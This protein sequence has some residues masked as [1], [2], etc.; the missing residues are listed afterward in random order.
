[1]KI[2]AYAICW[3]E[4][5]MLPY[6]LKH[7]ETFCDKI[8]IYD[9]ESTDNSRR[10]IKDHPKT[11]LRT[12]KT[13]SQIKDDVYLQIKESCV[14]DAKGKADYAIV[15]D[16]DEFL[17]HSNIKKF[18]ADN[19]S[20]SFYRPAGFEMVSEKFP[21]T[22]K[23]IYDECNIGI[24]T[25]KLCKP[26]LFNPNKIDELKLSV[27]GHLIYYLRHDY[28]EYRY[29]YKDS[30]ISEC[31]VGEGWNSDKKWL[32]E[33]NSFKPR[34]ESFGDSPLKLLHYKYIGL[35]YVTKRQKILAN[36]LSDKNIKNGWG[37]HY[38]KNVSKTF[39]DLKTKAKKINL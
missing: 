1:M 9:N 4:E 22:D 31:N 28:K 5:K 26:L 23:M 3:N 2:W 16:I 39:N 34:F 12:Y 17:Y 32:P 29:F 21:T 10:I 36:R 8:I 35:D 13:N 24:P 37:K 11:E 6:Y 14:Y 25:T 20:F 18:L 38:Y 19:S 27:G 7:Y 33:W 15:G 30:L